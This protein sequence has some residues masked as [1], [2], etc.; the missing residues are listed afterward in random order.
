MSPPLERNLPRLRRVF[1]SHLVKRCGYSLIKGSRQTVVN[2]DDRITAIIP[3]DD[4]LAGTGITDSVFHQIDNADLIIADLTSGRPAVAYELAMAHALGVYTALVNGFD[5]DLMFYLNDYRKVEIDLAD[6]RYDLASFSIPDD[7][8]AAI[9]SWLKE[10]LNIRNSTNPF[11]RFYGAP[12]CDISAACGLAAGFYQNFA[13]P[14]LLSGKIDSARKVSTKPISEANLQE[15]EGFIVFRPSRLDESIPDIEKALDDQLRKSF[16]SSRIKNGQNKDLIVHTD[17]GSRTVFYVVD[18]YVI[19]IPR[20]IFSLRQCY[21]MQRLELRDVSD[22]VIT[23]NQ[24]SA[25]MQEVLIERFFDDLCKRVEAE[26][27][28]HQDK[29]G[30]VSLKEKYH[31]GTLEEIP[32]IIKTGKSRTFTHEVPAEWKVRRRKRT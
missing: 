23:R 18:N 13:A 1:L 2:G 29:K 21:R 9:D 17:N 28:R 3:Q 6:Q 19:D 8:R 24:L 32:L 15:I 25:N 27:K 16:G 26:Y 20:T 10:R 7:V 11:T 12:L 5:K 31:V 14:I 30:E 22:D 4:G